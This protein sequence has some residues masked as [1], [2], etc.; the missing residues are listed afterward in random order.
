MGDYFKPRRRRIGLIAL[1]LACLLMVGWV[2]SAMNTDSIVIAAFQQVIYL[3]SCNGSL[4][5]QTNWTVDHPISIEWQSRP[6]K[7]FPF[8]S[9]WRRLGFAV[10]LDVM[11]GNSYFAV[12]H[13]FVALPLTMLSAWLL[14]S[15]TRT[16][17]EPVQR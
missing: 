16:Q 7:R 3:D 2:R 11:P 9:F 1:F 15:K 17:L 12:P 6:T 5:F 4:S 10:H 13:W 8:S 14:L